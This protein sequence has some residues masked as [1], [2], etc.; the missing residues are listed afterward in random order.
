[1][2]FQP[3]CG[4]QVFGPM[5]AFRSIG[6]AI[7]LVA[8][9]PAAAQ[10]WK[11]AYERGDIFRALDMLE[12][13]VFERDPMNDP[14]LDPMAPLY[15]ATY[16]VNGW[17]VKADPVMAC[18]LAFLA[19]RT[20][21]EQG[22]YPKPLKLALAALEEKTCGTLNSEQ[23]LD[24][25]ASVGCPN[26]GQAGQTI[27]FGDGS[28]V[29]LTPRRAIL[30]QP[31]RRT[32][33]E[34]GRG[35]AQQVLPAWHRKLVPPPGAAGHPRQLLELLAWYSSVVKGER[36]RTL[37]WTAWEVFD[38]A[39]VPT[40]AEIVANEPGS[41][42]PERPVPESV[43]FDF[44]FTGEGEVEYTFTTAAGERKRGALRPYDDVARSA[45]RRP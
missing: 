29:E 16:F 26:I 42:W 15:L 31:G 11:D 28:W 10:P 9:V 32:E 41:A 36:R 17:R 34:L 33:V 25:Y 18:S 2:D 6:V 44:R 35:C 3:V 43:R 39:L 37:H 14:K 45:L 8:A 40:A 13:L 1:M 4:S 7:V 24:A 19:G 12:P 38:G 30:D 23:R 22:R 27:R 21:D 5:G 20:A